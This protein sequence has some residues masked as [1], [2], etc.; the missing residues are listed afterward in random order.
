MAF[1]SVFVV[2]GVAAP[3]FAYWIVSVAYAAGNFS[4]AQADSL[5]AGSTP[6]VATTPAANSNTVGLTFDTSATTT[7]GRTVTSYVISRYATG[8]STPSVTFTCSPPSGSFTCTEGGVPDGSWQYTD[9]PTIAGS[10]WVGAESPKSIAVIVDTT[11]PTTSVSFPISGGYY[12][13]AGWT[14]GCNTSPFNVTDTIC[15][16][17][18][19]PGSFPSGVASVAVSVQSTS[20]STAGEY[21][22]G[23]S[24]NQSSEDKLAATYSAGQWTLAFPSGNFPADGSYIVRSYATDNDGN[25]Q[26][27]GTAVAF[28]IDNTAPTMVAPTATASVQYGSNPTYFDNEPVTLTE[29]ASDSGSGVKSVSYYYCA[30]SS[31]SCT[32]GTPWTLIGSSSTSS[33]N[34]AVTWNT[35]LPADGPYQIVAVGT[36]SAGNTSGSSPSTLVAV[37]TTPPTVTQPGVNG[38]T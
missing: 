16:T 32:S 4:V 24:F 36:D 5:P 14:A 26:S 23:S 20:G 22:G 31:G 10:S 11:P 7:S 2:A 12:N 3:A 33:G 27:P 30:G 1:A 17:A 8:S 15:G 28:G 25:V 6:T 9:A 35:P 21:W 29:A 34:F 13:N 38:Y 18:T 19:D 37:D